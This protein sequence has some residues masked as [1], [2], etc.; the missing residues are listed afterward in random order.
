MSV[1]KTREEFIDQANK[2]HNFKYNY[3]KVIY[4]GNRVKIKIICNNGHEFEQTPN[5]HLL[6][7]QG[8]P[9][10]AGLSKLTTNSFI[11]KA[12]KIHKN[13]YDYSLTNY[14]NATSKVKII[15]PEHGEFLQVAR[16]HTNSKQGCPTCGKA[17]NGWTKSNFINICTKNNNG[18]GILYVIKCFNQNE[19]FYK[20]GITSKSIKERYNT[21]HRMP[22][23]YEIIQEIT[24]IANNVYCLEKILCKIYCNYKYNPI[25]FFDGFTECFKI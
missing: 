25:I 2:V 12:K 19:E 3:N 6:Q 1:K 8:C 14:I 21:A 5:G 17:I 23:Q 9:F 16:N 20:I 4:S 11:E 18:L 22:Y 24:D 15:C 7:K 13:K 10:C